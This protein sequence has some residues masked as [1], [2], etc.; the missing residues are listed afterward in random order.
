[1]MM[2]ENLLGNVSG[3]RTLRV[4]RALKSVSIAF[5][6]TELNW[7]LQ[8]ISTAVHQLQSFKGLRFFE[9]APTGAPNIVHSV[10]QL[11]R[12]VFGATLALYSVC[13]TLYR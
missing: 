9:C 1:M 3:I 7:F 2:F 4:L 5:V 11:T 6:F 8:L 12:N 10:V 13:C